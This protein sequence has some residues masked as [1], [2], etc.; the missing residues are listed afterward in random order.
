[1]PSPMQIKIQDELNKNLLE[2]ILMHCNGKYVVL[3]GTEHPFAV[4]RHLSHA[5]RRF[6]PN[7]I[8]QAC[9]KP[10]D[11]VLDKPDNQYWQ[12]VGAEVCINDCINALKTIC[13][14]N[15]EFRTPIFGIIL[16]F[17]F[18]D[19]HKYPNKKIEK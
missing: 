9:K 15:W 1:M 6:C 10:P 7:H 18:F 8:K 13:P 14:A 12:S 4:Y 2:Y 3:A 11:N 19:I 16:E 17:G 5:M